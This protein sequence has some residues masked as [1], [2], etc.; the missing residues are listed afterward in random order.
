M[1]KPEYAFFNG[2]IVPMA[3]AK[4]SV[5]TH[6]LHY[7]T[8]V[9][10]GMRAYWND[11]EQQLFI[12]RALDHFERFRQSAGLLRITVPHT[13][14]ELTEI[15]SELLRLEDYHEN[16]YIRPLTFK[17]EDIGVDQLADLRDEI[18]IFAKPV[19]GYT[20]NPVGK[21]VG[22]SAWR[23][24]EDNAIPARGKVAGAYANSSLIKSAALYAGYDEALVLTEDGHL[25]EASTSNVFIVRKGVLITPSITS[26]V[27]EGIVRRSVIELARNELGLQVVEREVD[28]T[29]A[30]ICDE[31]FLCGTGMQVQPVTQI[32]HR[33]I[34]S[35]SMG[36]ITAQIRQLFFDVVR[37]YEPKY[38]HWLTPV[39]VPEP[40]A[41]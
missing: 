16:V 32:E 23:R 27:L 20:E 37:G 35:G 13:E 39:Y 40:I 24:V 10:A 29:E 15:L 17:G 31:M 6:A 5:M 38:R 25:S 11:D 7:G 3:D 1:T 2:K 18:T 28:R 41:K 22:Y 4:V 14:A 30:Y 34:G 26:N 19:I 36:P 21:H 9:F 8:G 33:T 12:F